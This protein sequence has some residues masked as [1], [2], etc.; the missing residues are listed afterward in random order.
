MYRYQVRKGNEM[1]TIE[2]I[3]QGEKY[4]VWYSKDRT[5]N[6]DKDNLTKNYY[7][8]VLEHVVSLKNIDTSKLKP[9]GYQVDSKGLVFLV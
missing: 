6:Y 1:R 8:P 2:E 9:I 3:A 4:E 7:I 5:C